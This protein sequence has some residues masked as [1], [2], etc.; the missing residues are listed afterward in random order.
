MIPD[1][2]NEPC[3]QPERGPTALTTNTLSLRAEALLWV[4]NLG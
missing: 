3:C 2:G 1:G 4:H